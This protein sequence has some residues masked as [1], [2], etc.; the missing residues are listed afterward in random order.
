M[1]LQLTEFSDKEGSCL[2]KPHVWV[3]LTKK[4]GWRG[5]CSV[6]LKLAQGRFPKL[7]ASSDSPAK[8]FKAQLQGPPRPR[9][10]W[11]NEKP[12]MSSYS[13]DFV[14]VLNGHKK[15]II[16]HPETQGREWKI[17]VHPHLL[18]LKCKM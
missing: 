15:M 8:G 17:N 3:Y 9:G 1:T 6:V 4:Q 5:G 18:D 7:P 16:Q 12:S 2:L 13:A 11:W 10:G 14:V